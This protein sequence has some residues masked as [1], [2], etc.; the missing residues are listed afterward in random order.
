MENKTSLE[1]IVRLKED[2]L[3]MN[4]YKKLQNARV[5]LGKRDIKKSGYNGHAKF[6]YYEI[7]DFLPTVNEIFLNWGLT[8]QESRLKG[9]DT[10]TI[11]NVDNPEEQILFQVRTDIEGMRAMPQ[12]TQEVQK[13]GSSLT[14]VKRYNWLNALG[15]SEGDVIDATIGAEEPKETKPKKPAKPKVETPREKAIA[16]AN[17]LIEKKVYDSM[18]TVAKEFGLTPDTTDAEY[19]DVIKRMTIKLG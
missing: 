15:L 3:T 19:E 8:Y 11:I 14:Y 2:V 4:V 17:V 6:Y 5:E 16:M 13:L 1:E 12:G 10:L 9:K 18:A 7:K